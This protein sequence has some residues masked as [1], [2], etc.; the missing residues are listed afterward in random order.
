[1][2]PDRRVVVGV[3]YRVQSLV[4]IGPSEAI[5][6]DLVTLPSL[7]LYDIPLIVQFFL[8]QYW[9]QGAHAVG[10]HPEAQLR[11]LTGHLLVVDGSIAI[12]GAVGAGADGL[13]RGKVLVV[14]M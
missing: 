9:Q 13:K 6:S 3:P 4:Q 1:M 2:G 14:E 8:G 7:V 5:G 11:E 10:L 12:G